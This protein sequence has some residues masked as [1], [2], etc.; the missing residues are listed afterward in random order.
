[1]FINFGKVAINVYIS[2]SSAYL[3]VQKNNK[4]SIFSIKIG[5][6]VEMDSWILTL[7]WTDTTS[8]LLQMLNDFFQPV[9]DFTLIKFVTPRLVFK[10]LFS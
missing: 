7:L 6:C 3:Q 1:M 2:Y 9:G 8:S 10:Q 5:N 4:K